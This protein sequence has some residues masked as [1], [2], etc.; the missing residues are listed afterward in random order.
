MEARLLILNGLEAGTFIALK[1]DNLIGRSEGCLIRPTH[2]A[3][4]RRHCE[5]TLEESGAFIKDLGSTNGTF[6]NG[7]RIHS[8][9][10]LS[11]GDRINAAVVEF[12]FVF[13]EDLHEV[14]NEIVMDEHCDKITL[15]SSFLD[16]F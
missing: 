5:I 15:K 12:K 9:M 11:D 13:S 1:K 14:R 16:R 6:V 7:D 10:Q 4:S 2:P 3:V 8:R